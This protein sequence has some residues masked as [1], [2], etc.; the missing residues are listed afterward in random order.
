M[1]VATCLQGANG[2]AAAAA[3]GVAADVDVC[4]LHRCSYDQGS[5]LGDVSRSVLLA[6]VWD[7]CF[8]LLGRLGV[9]TFKFRLAE[10]GE[11]QGPRAK[12]R[13]CGVA[14]FEAHEDALEHLGRAEQAVALELLPVLLGMLQGTP[15][16][17]RWL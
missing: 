6:E 16:L 12:A 11:G 7:S 2:A 14:L 4:F 10:L 17:Y 15:L 1:H 13:K 8:R 5:W 9:R 3:A